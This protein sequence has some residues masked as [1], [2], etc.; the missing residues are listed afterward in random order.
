[1]RNLFRWNYI[2]ETVSLIG[3]E[4]LKQDGTDLII[5]SA[6]TTAS[7][8]GSLTLVTLTVPPGTY[9]VIGDVDFFTNSTSGAVLEMSYT[10]PGTS[11][12]VKRYLGLAA[13]GYVSA[14]HNFG[15]NPFAAVFNPAVLDTNLTITFSTTAVDADQ[16]VANVS[17]VLR[18]VKP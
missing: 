3:Q 1:M 2:K 5:A 10:Q 6:N 17:Y 16:Y 4:S 8:A 18:E 12:V 9:C 11:T 15:D 7:A 14:P 13:A